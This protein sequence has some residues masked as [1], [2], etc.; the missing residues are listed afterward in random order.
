MSGLAGSGIAVDVPAG[1]DGRIYTR[2]PE[3]SGLRPA[4]AMAAQQ[5]TTGAVLHVAS[6]PL[7]PDTGDYG[8][9]AVELMTST[10][11]LIVLFEH[12]AQSANTPLF[13]ATSIPRLVATDVSTMQLQRLLEGQGGVQRFFTIAGRA[14]CLYVVFGSYARCV[15]TVPVVNSI[16]DTITIS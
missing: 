14:F 11:L 6:F 12:G 9:G 2:S 1:W 15:R 10:D 7:P 8:G 13:A 3:P 5:E 4:S 16:L